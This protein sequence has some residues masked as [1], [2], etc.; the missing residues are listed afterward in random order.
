MGAPEYK[1]VSQK[2]YNKTEKRIMLKGCEM[3]MGDGHKMN[4]SLKRGLSLTP[5][6]FSVLLT[7]PSQTKWI[8]RCSVFQYYILELFHILSGIKSNADGF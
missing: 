2:S 8:K 6:L 3:K 5:P 7:P 1:V 4:M